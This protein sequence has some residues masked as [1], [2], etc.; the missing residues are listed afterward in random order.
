MRLYTDSWD[1][2]DVVPV[3]PYFVGEVQGAEK[4]NK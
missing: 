3:L 4:T 1:I 2:C